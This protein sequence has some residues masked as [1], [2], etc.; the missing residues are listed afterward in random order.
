LRLLVIEQ[1]DLKRWEVTAAKEILAEDSPSTESSEATA[2]DGGSGPQ[3]KSP[4]D[5]TS[6]ASKPPAKKLAPWAVLLA[7]VRSPRGMSGF[8]TTF[9]FG[10]VLGCLE[11]TYV[12]LW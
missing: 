9:I 1:K 3:P 8:L 5:I 4:D 6:R 10:L 7:L 12:V 11:P 2:H